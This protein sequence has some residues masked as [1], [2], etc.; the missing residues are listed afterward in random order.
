MRGFSDVTT[1]IK[2]LVKYVSVR[3]AA[4]VGGG[5]VGL[6]IA[7]AQ[8]GSVAVVDDSGHEVALDRP[9]ERVITLAPHLTEQVYTAGGGDRIVATVT[10][11]NFPPAA[12]QIL[13]IGSYKKISFEMVVG[14]NPDLVIAFGGNGWA[15]IN[16]LRDLGYAVYV[17][18]PRELEDVS[19]TL[20]RL[21]TLLGTQDVADAQARRFSDRLN[22]L[23]ARFGGKESVRV[24]YEV[25]NR[26]LITINGEHLISSVMRLCGGMNI[27]S[28]AL[29][30]APRISVE[31]VVER[32]PEVIIASGHGDERPEWLDEW[33][34]WP[35]ISAV[36]RGNLRFIHPDIL[37]R[38]TVRILDG[39]EQ[40]C[41]HLDMARTS[42]F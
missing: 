32:D 31:S 11:S 23:R 39:A 7:C 8:A 12:G 42:R 36:K 37:Q 1:S 13:K 29:S 9:A 10:Y 25:W 19:A 27:F 6:F 40:M 14:L 20:V 5:A 2:T 24:F 26:P 28:E 16:R 3:P 17:D 4:L 34:Q 41:E 38:H 30:M 21:G 15:M 18:E 22:R 33:L 35:S